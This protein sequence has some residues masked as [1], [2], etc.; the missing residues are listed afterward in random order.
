M[1]RGIVERFT[2]HHINTILLCARA[3]KKYRRTWPDIV[4]TRHS[5]WL[6]F[7]KN[8]PSLAL[9]LCSK[10]KSTHFAVSVF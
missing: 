6:F 3:R 1:V 7:K 9:E 8:C 2:T 4:Q 10:N 5:K